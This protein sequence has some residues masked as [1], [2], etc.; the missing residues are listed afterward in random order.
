MKKLL[1]VKEFQQQCSRVLPIIL[2]KDVTIFFDG[3]VDKYY[4]CDFQTEKFDGQII[5]ILTDSL[6]GMKLGYFHLEV[7]GPYLAEGQNKTIAGAF[8]KMFSN[9]VKKLEEDKKFFQNII[10]G[11]AKVNGVEE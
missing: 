5:Y 9:A 8:R 4:S 1:T 7:G 2:G 11:L 10:S 3:I 6:W